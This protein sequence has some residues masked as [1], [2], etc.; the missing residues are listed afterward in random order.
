[1]PAPFMDGRVRAS[2]PVVETCDAPVGQMNA[3]GS[4]EPVEGLENRPRGGLSG[5]IASWLL[6]W[7][8]RRHAARKIDDLLAWY[9]TVKTDHPDWAD[10]EHYKLVIMARARCDS[11]AADAILKCAE[12]SFAEWPARRELT[13]C[14]VVHYLSVTEFLATHVGQP[15]IHSNIARVVTSHVPRDLCISRAIT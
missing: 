8:E 7:H 5:V 15:G 11:I 2:S 13:L 1:M 9:R 12:E 4:R 14:Y 6:L 3:S 10:R